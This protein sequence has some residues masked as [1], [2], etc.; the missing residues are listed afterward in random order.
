MKY[1]VID[2]IKNK[3]KIIRAFVQIK[4]SYPQLRQFPMRKSLKESGI[5]LQGNY[6][7][8]C[9]EEVED[10]WNKNGSRDNFYAK[11]RKKM[12]IKN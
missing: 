11:V 1:I 2:R 9:A 4:R 5:Y 6:E 7:V 3:A 8:L 12:Q 10:G